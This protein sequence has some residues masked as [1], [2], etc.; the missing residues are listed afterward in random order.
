M[1]TIIKQQQ[2]IKFRAV[3]IADL[4]S[5]VKLYLKQKSIFDSALTHQFGMPLCVAEWNNKIVGYSSV[6]TTNTE[7]YNLNT[8][9]DSYFS[10]NEID[11][12]LL[13]ESEPFFKKEWQN[14]S[15]KNLSISITHLVDWLNNSNS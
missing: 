10:N 8:H 1:E 6:T 11:E 4:D 5:I 12:S 7:N 2:N 13:Q 14:G 3:T 9:I 15:N